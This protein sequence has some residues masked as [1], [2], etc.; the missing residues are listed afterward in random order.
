M[1]RLRSV[2]LAIFVIT[3]ACVCVLAQTPNQPPAKITYIKAGRLF[4]STSDSF[5]TNMVIEVSGDRIQRIGTAAE[6]NIPAGS[7]VVDLSNDTVLPG[8]IDCHTHLGSRADR[9]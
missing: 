5:K 8:L 6:V 4:D 7:N 3:F 2:L 1:N 9:Y